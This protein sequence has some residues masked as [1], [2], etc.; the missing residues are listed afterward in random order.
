MN[1]RKLLFLLPVA[2]LLVIGCS[3]QTQANDSLRIVKFEADWCGPC[4]QMKPV[5]D[6]VSRNLSDMA[7]FETVN[8]DTQPSLAEAYQ[9]SA[10]PTVIAIKN[11]KIVAREI[12]YM[13]G[14]RLK[15]FVKRHR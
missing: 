7:T 1:A 2:A 11:G 8:V 13:D 3:E 6:R 4:Q 14:F 9:V 12:G 5:F 15:S 10:L